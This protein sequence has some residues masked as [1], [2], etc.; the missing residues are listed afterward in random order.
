[1]YD[2]LG[3]TLYSVVLRIRMKNLNVGIIVL[4]LTFRHTTWTYLSP[5]T[6]QLYTNTIKRTSDEK[7]KL[8]RCIPYESDSQ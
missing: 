2:K 4:R 7:Y 5:A 3:I 6:L 8:K 1:M